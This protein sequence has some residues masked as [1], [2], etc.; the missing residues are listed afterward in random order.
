MKESLG[1]FGWHTCGTPCLMVKAKSSSAYIALHKFRRQSLW[2]WLPYAR[3][4]GLVAS[5]PFGSCQVIVSALLVSCMV[6]LLAP[7][8]VFS[9]GV[10]HVMCRHV[11]S[12]HVMSRKGG[13]G[14]ERREIREEGRE[15][16]TPSMAAWH[17]VV[18]GCVS[19]SRVLSSCVLSGT[20]RDSPRKEITRPNMMGTRDDVQHEIK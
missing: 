20:R 5:L 8:H 15:D 2:T 16:R 6:R 12:A 18:S 3:P 13:E 11:M 17:V 14:E 9:S 7:C 10:M 1:A 4:G 19:S